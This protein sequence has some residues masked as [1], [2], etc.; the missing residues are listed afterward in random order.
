[1]I[2]V[3][4]PGLYTSVQDQGRFGFY[5]LGFPPSGSMDRFSSDVAN[6]LV[7]ND[8]KAAV[9]ETTFVGPTLEFETPATIAITGADALFTIDGSEAP[10][11]TTFPV[12]AGQTLKFA[13][14]GSGARNYLAFRGGINCRPIMGSRS[15]YAAS[16][17]GGISG[18][19]L[20][21][22]DTFSLGEASRCRD[23]SVGREVP[24]ALRPRFADQQEIRIVEG[25]C[26]YLLSDESKWDL[27]HATF[28]VSTEANRI[29]YR[30][31]GKS[32]TFIEREQPFGAGSDPSNVVNLGYPVGS[33]QS[34]SGAELICL[35]RDAVTGG[36]YA[37][38]ATVISTDLDL[39]AQ[40]K[41][42]E[43][44]RFESVTLEQAIEARSDRRARLTMIEQITSDTRAP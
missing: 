31:S 4:H 35:M 38:L 34:P 20:Q 21:A 44:V 6:I 13:G 28:S 17:L 1:M 8:V 11:W 24:V 40:M 15:T 43:A 3:A 33:L 7:G 10:L 29:G 42:P 9:L 26:H 18:G 14:L 12:Q 25:L 41:F 23:V 30:L 36:G 5:G 27:L 39:L 32:L 16:H 22:G 19:T 2:R 37:T